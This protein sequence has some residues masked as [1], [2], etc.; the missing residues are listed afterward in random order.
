MQP[1]WLSSAAL[2][3]GAFLFFTLSLQLRATDFRPIRIRDDY[4]HDRFD[5]RPKEIIWEFEAFFT[6]FDWVKDDGQAW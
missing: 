2:F 4:R 5:T 6:S 1:R 3:L